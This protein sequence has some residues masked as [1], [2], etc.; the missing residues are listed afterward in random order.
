MMDM[1]GDETMGDSAYSYNT[2]PR[3]FG[4]TG[5][6]AATDT[7]RLSLD[8]DETLGVESDDDEL[9]SGSQTVRKHM[10]E[11]RRALGEDGIETGSVS[12]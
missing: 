4:E 10:R 8:R 9:D 2:A 1:I 6:M 7:M 5:S 11:T 12:Q 3:A